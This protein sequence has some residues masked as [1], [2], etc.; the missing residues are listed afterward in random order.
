MKSKHFLVIALGILAIGCIYYFGNT[1]KP[2]APVVET[3][4]EDDGH[5]H[6]PMTMNDITPA[7][8][9]SL[10]AVAKKKVSP[11]ILGKLRDLEQS[12][13]DATTNE[14]KAIYLDAIGRVWYDQKN[15]LMAAYY[16]GNSGKLD[17]SEKKLNFASHLLSEDIKTETDPSVRKLMYDLALSYFEQSEKVNPNDAS[18]QIDHAMLYIDGG[19]E[20][21]TGVGKLLAIVEKDPKNIPATI[22]LGK[23]AIQSGQFD[24]AVERA[25]IILNIDNK[26]L[27]AYLFKAD[28]LFKLNKIQEGKKVLEEAKLMMNNPEF[29]KDVDE[30]IKNIE[31]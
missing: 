16:V 8:F 26:V 28:A 5:E 1:V 17:N 14:Q 9:E 21:M 30:Y 2:K 15:R 27:D 19:G 4:T 10:L 31:K 25:D 29:S 22:I 18:V 23:M 7:N 24:K 12:L 3:H 13:A 6:A 20:I 11:Q